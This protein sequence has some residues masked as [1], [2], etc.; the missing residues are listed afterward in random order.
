MKLILTEKNTIE[1][2]TAGWVAKRILKDECEWIEVD[3]SKRGLPDVQGLD[4]IMFGLSY[5][6]EILRTIQTRAKSLMVYD[7]SFEA[8]QEIGGLR[9]VKIETNKTPARM[10]WNVLRGNM[11]ITVN[12]EKIFLSSAPWIVD[13]SDER[14][15]WRWPN[16]KRYFIQLAILKKY[17][18]TLKSWDSLAAK[19]L[20]IVEGEG[21][22][23]ARDA[24]QESLDDNKD[25]PSGGNNEQ[26][27]T[28][29]KGSGKGKG[30]SKQ[31]RLPK[32]PK[33]RTR[34]AKRSKK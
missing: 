23:V 1:G 7:N 28:K 4:V 11:Q 8:K 33:A 30:K 16:A 2:F 22:Q 20:M 31:S 6:R 21:L 19:D 25:N 5:G 3:P 13:Y 26:S 12:K 15:L 24:N 34:K 14:S 10:A 27:T 32:V 18:L 9:C 29:E 17:E